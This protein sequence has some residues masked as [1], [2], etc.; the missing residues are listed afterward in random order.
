MVKLL[1][2]INCKLIGVSPAHC[3]TSV[4]EAYRPAALQDKAGMKP[5]G[6]SATDWLVLLRSVPLR[7]PTIAPEASAVVHSAYTETRNRPG[8]LRAHKARFLDVF[9]PVMV[10]GATRPR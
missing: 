8:A 1:K 5:D 9:N 2:T 6:V 10:N 4:S 7:L 3:T